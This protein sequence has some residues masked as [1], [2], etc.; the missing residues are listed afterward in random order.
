MP[1]KNPATSQKLKHAFQFA[2]DCHE[3]Q[4]RKSTSIPYISHLM[5]VSALV[6]E[7]GGD[8]DQAIAALLHD[9]VEDADSDTEANQRRQ[10]IAEQFGDRVAKIVD[11]CTD[12]IPDITGKK[13]SWKDRKVA[14]LEHLKSADQDTLLVSAADKLHNARAILGDL[15]VVGEAV[16]ERFRAG[17]EGTLWY[18]SSLADTFAEIMPGPLAAELSRT[19]ESIMK[20]G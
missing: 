3:T 2:C 1:K 6:F 7:Y 8:E 10:F 16:Y 19:V 18:Y 15:R 12:G 13:P 11:G 14:Y 9:S 4:V 17:K 20:A 5:S